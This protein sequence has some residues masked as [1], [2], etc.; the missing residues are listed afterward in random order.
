MKKCNCSLDTS[1]LDSE[2]FKG[3]VKGGEKISFAHDG[4]NNNFLMY[5]GLQTYPLNSEVTKSSFALS[6]CEHTKS[7]LI[8][9]FLPS[10]LLESLI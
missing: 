7:C 2:L 8:P 5:F 1:G 3:G 9:S 10:F 6:G 4:P